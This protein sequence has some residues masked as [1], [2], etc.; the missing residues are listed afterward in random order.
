M[1]EKYLI[2]RIGL[3]TYA[4]YGWGMQ[5]TSAF[6]LAFVLRDKSKKKKPVTSQ[7]HRDVWIYSVILAM[8][9]L[10]FVTT[11]KNSDSSSLTSVSATA[12]VAFTVVVAYFVLHEKQF[13]KLKFLGLGLSAI[14][15][16]LLFT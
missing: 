1:N 4:L 15:L 14:G 6:F 12:K 11:L 3:E 10:S 2:D 8:A 13:V 7:M 16:F 5:A 9:G